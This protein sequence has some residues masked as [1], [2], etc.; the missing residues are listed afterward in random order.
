MKIFKE[1]DGDDLLEERVRTDITPVPDSFSII[2]KENT[3]VKCFLLSS[4]W[5][6]DSA[7]NAF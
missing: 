6:V 3:F 1:L 5:V 7:L 4:F 2:T